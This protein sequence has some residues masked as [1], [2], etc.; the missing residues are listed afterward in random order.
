MLNTSN[1][2]LNCIRS[3]NFHGYSTRHR[4]CRS[5]ETVLGRRGRK[6]APRPVLVGLLG[7]ERGQGDAGLDGYARS[8]HQTL[9]PAVRHDVGGVNV[10]DVLAIAVQE[11]DAL[12]VGY[13]ASFP[14]VRSNRELMPGSAW[15]L[16]LRNALHSCHGVAQCGSWLKVPNCG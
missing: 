13:Q 14:S 12:L 7:H 16:S 1:P 5:P 9:H 8:E 10:E 11:P 2:N 15:P 3:V 4:P 6:W